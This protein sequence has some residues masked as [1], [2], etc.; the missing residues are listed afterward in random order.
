MV[1]ACELQI[2]KKQSPESPFNKGDFLCTVLKLIGMLNI[3]PTITLQLILF[4]GYL[5]NLYFF[6]FGVFDE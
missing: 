1:W 2:T 4:L 6:N 5:D 3:I